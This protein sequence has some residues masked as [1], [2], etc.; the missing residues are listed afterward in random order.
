MNRA[1]VTTL[2]T[3]TPDPQRGT[4]LDA[5]PATFAVLA[6]SLRRHNIPLV[7]LADEL[8]EAD[9]AEVVRVDADGINPY[10]ARWQLIAEWLDDQPQLNMLFCV[11]A[12]DVELLHDPFDE[13]VPGVLY[14]GSEPNRV[15]FAWV[16][17]N[18]PSARALVSDCGDEQLLNPGILG[19]DA[20]TMRAFLADLAPRL[21]IALDA[22]DLVD[23]AA[24]N[25]VIWRTTWRARISTGRQVHTLFRAFDTAGP[26][27]WRHK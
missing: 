25:D 12:T 5:D 10:I 26:S 14:I 19:G 23:M 22:G 16:A 17:A 27:W 9:N 2:L 20:V 6:A 4:H 3:A 7:V 21:D 15:D 11:D 1:V 18:H 8:D 24:I 13:M